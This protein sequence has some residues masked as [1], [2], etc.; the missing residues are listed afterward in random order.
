LSREELNV[1][2]PYDYLEQF[3]QAIVLPYI[4]ILE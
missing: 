1:S 4:K 3:D 2:D